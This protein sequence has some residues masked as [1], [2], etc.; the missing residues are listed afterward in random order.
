MKTTAAQEKTVLSMLM[1]TARDAIPRMRNTV[2]IL[3]RFIFIIYLT[4]TSLKSSN[5]PLNN[6]GEFILKNKRDARE[7]NA[8]LFF[9]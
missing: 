1:P 3:R 5:D 8:D 9:F 2:E 6:V 4:F 7:T